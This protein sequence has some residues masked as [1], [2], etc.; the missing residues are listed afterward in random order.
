MVNARAPLFSMTRSTVLIVTPNETR[1][2]E[3]DARVLR[4]LKPALL[5]LAGA[6]V[7]GRATRRHG[8]RRSASA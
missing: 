6:S 2:L 4:W 8:K 3:V 7:P 1:S 5:G